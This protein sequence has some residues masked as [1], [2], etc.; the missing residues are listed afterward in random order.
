MELLEENGITLGVEY[1]ERATGELKVRHTPD[2]P[3]ENTCTES[4][5]SPLALVR[6][7]N[8]I[9]GRSHPSNEDLYVMITC[10]V[11]SLAASVCSPDSCG[12]WLLL[13]VPQEPCQTL[14][15]NSQPL[16]R[17]VPVAY[18]VLSVF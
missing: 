17:C 3:H 12:R 8:F 15:Y 10:H 14:S 2:M 13:Q 6:A 9:C 4:L 16:R 11:L 7:I 18:N 1:K 5:V